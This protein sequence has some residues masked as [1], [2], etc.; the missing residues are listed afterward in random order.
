LTYD[1][2][3]PGPFAVEH[4]TFEL[5]DH[6]RGRAFPIDVWQPGPIA[7]RRPVIVFSH[8][9]GQH[10]RSATFL[11]TQ[12]CSHGYAVAAMDHSEVVTPE[13]ARVPG[14]TEAQKRAG[15]R[16]LPAASPTFAFSST[17]RRRGGTRSRSDWH[18]RPQLRRLDR[19]R[20]S[21]RRAADRGCRRAR[22]G[23]RIP[24]QTG[25]FAGEARFP[26]GA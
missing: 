24:T 17:P 7:E 15:R 12:L 13:L 6:A 10:R 22:A 20:R 5:R 21:R 9:A 4:R 14:E 2:F 8:A 18:R 26:L 16:S 3:A 25:H 23:G 11:C 1:P 19:A